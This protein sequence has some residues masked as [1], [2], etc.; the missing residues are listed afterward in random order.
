MSALFAH[1]RTLIEKNGPISLA[2]YM[3]LALQH[4][5]HGYYR[6]N[7]PLGQDGDFI[8]AP[9]I[10]QMFGELIG[11]CF[12][13]AW[14]EMDRPE[15]FV[16][17]ELG[18]GR[19]TL[20]QDALRA[21]HKMHDFHSAMHVYLLESNESLRGMQREK[22]AAYGPHYLDDPGTLP[23]LPTFIVAN[24]F[25]DALPVRQFENTEQGWRER[26]VTVDGDELEFVLSKPDPAFLLFIPQELRE[27][28]IGTVHEASLPA[29]ALMRQLAQHVAQNGGAM[30]IM[31]YGYAAPPGK[32]TLQA[33]SKHRQADVLERPGE[34]DLTAHVDFAALRHIAQGQGAVTLGPIG[35]GEFLQSLGIE[36]R[37][38]QLKYNASPDQARAIDAALHRLTDPSEMGVLFKA[39]AVVSP[40]LGSLA[41]F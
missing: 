2:R 18:P 8:T 17:L 34:V 7:D 4:P 29:L 14:K 41:G 3:E 24:E 32:G 9:E 5:E 12:A 16:L 31:D 38:L 20:M 27:A 26:L 11:L 30:L 6:R 40:S 19:G 37:A 39:M 36:M 28:P 1:I 22:L 25:F 21:T 13:E 10:S 23:A 15:K 35:Q 33:A